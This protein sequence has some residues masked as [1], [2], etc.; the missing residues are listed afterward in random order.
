MT[1]HGT[2]GIALKLSDMAGTPVFATV[3]QGVTVT[4]P[5]G[6]RGAS[7]IAEHDMTGSVEKLPDAL[8]DEG[9]IQLTVDLDPA[10]ATHDETTGIE[11]AYVS[12]DLKNWQLVFPDVGAKQADFAAYVQ[13][14]NYEAYPASAGVGQATITLDISGDITW[15]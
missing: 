6:S 14:R 8:R 10:D 9:T 5:Q 3:A 4:P 12:G 1:Q 13:S 11:E 2:H 15:T 7:V